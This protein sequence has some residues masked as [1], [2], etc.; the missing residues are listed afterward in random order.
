[1]WPAFVVLC[2]SIFSVGLRA[3]AAEKVR[4]AVGA[5]KA[6]AG[7]KSALGTTPKSDSAYIPTLDVV[8]DSCRKEH[9]K[10]CLKRRCVPALSYYAWLTRE[11]KDTRSPEVK[12]LLGDFS[13]PID[14]WPDKDDIR[15]LKKA[16]GDDWQAA[17]DACWLPGRCCFMASRPAKRIP[18]L[19]FLNTPPFLRWK[20]V[21]S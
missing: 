3:E 20:P 7:P 6:T 14:P 19:I 9:P 13:A 21:M 8:R 11:E 15:R 1:M 12:K 10:K 4:A 16:F 18:W 2:A 5:E 17:R